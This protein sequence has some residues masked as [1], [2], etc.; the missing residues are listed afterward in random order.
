MQPMKHRHRAMLLALSGLALILGCRAMTPAPTPEEV[1]RGTWRNVRDLDGIEV[2]QLLT[3]T[4]SRFIYQATGLSRP[5]VVS[6]KWSANADVIAVTMASS[7]GT[8]TED[9]MF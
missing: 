6:G 2:T 7:A 3:L 4:K 1:L 8:F 5:T 9:Q